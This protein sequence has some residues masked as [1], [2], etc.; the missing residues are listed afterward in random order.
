MLDD[1]SSETSVGSEANAPPPTFTLEA[2]RSES[3]LAVS[4]TPVTFERHATDV[5]ERIAL[6]DPLDVPAPP[7]R[8]AARLGAWQDAKK[9]AAAAVLGIAL[10]AIVGFSAFDRD[11]SQATR[12][13][14]AVATS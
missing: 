10:G 8:R 3:E 5:F 1:F 13:P 14:S 7:T 11:V 6:L 9:L 12:P 2:F 4:A